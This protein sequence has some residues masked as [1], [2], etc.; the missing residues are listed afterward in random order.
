[1]AINDA[2][3]DRIETGLAAVSPSASSYWYDYDNINERKPPN[4]TYPHVIIESQEEVTFGDPEEIVVNAYDNTFL[5]NFIITVDNTDTNTYRAMNRAMDD[6]R[7]YMEEDHDN[8]Q[9]V[10]MIYANYVD[11]NFSYTNKRNLPGIV[12]VTFRIRY[13]VK[14][15]DPDSTQ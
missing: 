14:R 6:V 1:M 8:L 12:T 9:A 5:V 10:G 7:R 11:A 2:I 15:T 3:V 13:R 4:K